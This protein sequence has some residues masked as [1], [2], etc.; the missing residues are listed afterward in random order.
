MRV[1][2]QRQGVLPVLRV[3]ASAH[4]EA[5]DKF[6]A[7]DPCRSLQRLHYATRHREA[8]R[9]ARYSRNH[10][11]QFRFADAGKRVSLLQKT[12]KAIHRLN[13]KGV[14]SLRAI[15]IRHILVAVKIDQV[16]SDLTTVPLGL[17]EGLLKAVG[18]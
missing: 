3:K 4:T 5:P 10:Q 13:E 9:C 6:V 11:A 1:L 12:S 18:K 7:V 14:G 8:V 2:L 15:G 16:D 17:G